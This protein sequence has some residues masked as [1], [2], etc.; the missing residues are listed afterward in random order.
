M[1]EVRKKSTAV[2]L[3]VRLYFLFLKS[4][5]AFPLIFLSTFSLVIFGII[6]KLCANT[7]DSPPSHLVFRGAHSSYAKVP[8]E[9]QK[10]YFIRSDTFSNMKEPVIRALNE[11]GWRRSDDANTANLIWSFHRQ[12]AMTWY[13]DELHALKPYQR[14]NHLSSAIVWESK[15]NFA[16]GI[17]IYRQRNPEISLHMFPEIYLLQTPEGIHNWRLRLFQNG[18]MDEPWVLKAEGK[19]GGKGIKVLGPNSPELQSTE[20]TLDLHRADSHRQMVQ[21]YICNELT[22]W[23]NQK[24]DLRFYWMVASLDPL[25]VLFHDGIARVGNAKYDEKDFS[26]TEKHLTTYTDQPTEFKAPCKDVE[27]LV[28]RHYRQNERELREHVKN[29]PWQH[30][31]NQMKESIA[32]TVDAFK[33][34]TFGFQDEL[35]SADSGFAV[36][37]CDFVIDRNLHTSYLEPQ[38]GPGLEE[39]SN[40]RISL[41]QDMFLSAFRMVEEVQRKLEVD[42][43]KN[44]LPLKNQG[45]WE[46]IYAESIENSWMYRYEGFTAPRKKKCATSPSS[47]R[48]STRRLRQW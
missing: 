21:A 5:Y 15:W 3:K 32:I 9:F 26:S 2:S 20:S 40:F 17:D 12:G 45:N 4:S 14:H 38:L 1:A 28:R 33:H 8:A 18:G 36:Y 16:R 30:V 19:N 27:A 10:T 34:R 42:P 48:T 11:L 43:T 29:D 23:G 37:G 13:K 39:D 6:G 25:I 24:F 31:R 41:H 35:F 47:S 44:V 22:W 7:R 46:I